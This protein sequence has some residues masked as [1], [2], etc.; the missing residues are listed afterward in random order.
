MGVGRD[1][2]GGPVTA[3]LKNLPNGKSVDVNVLTIPADKTS[4]VVTLCRPAK[5]L[6]GKFVAV[7][8]ESYAAVRGQLFCIW[9]AVNRARK[10]AG[11]KLMP[12]GVCTGRAVLRVTGRGVVGAGKGNLRAVAG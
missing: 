9:W 7:P 2:F 4:L 1:N 6:A 8:H 12:A 5:V 10:F 11:Y 3:A